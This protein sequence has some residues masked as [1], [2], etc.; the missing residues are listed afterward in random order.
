[1]KVWIVYKQYFGT[2]YYDLNSA[3]IY[4]TEEAARNR[5]LNLQVGD[6]SIDL[7]DVT[8]VENEICE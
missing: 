6:D 1:M 2:D 4:T 5:M 8:I 7:D 3:E